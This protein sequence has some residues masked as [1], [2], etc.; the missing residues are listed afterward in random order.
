MNDS[1]GRLN[2]RSFLCRFRLPKSYAVA[3]IMLLGFTWTS[4]S[5]DVRCEPNDLVVEVRKIWEAEA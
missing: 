1:A 5:R 4:G 2:R 3:L